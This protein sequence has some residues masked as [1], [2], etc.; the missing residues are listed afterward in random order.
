MSEEETVKSYKDRNVWMRG[1]YMVIFM[2]FWGVAEFV[3]FF[4]VLVQFLTVLFTAKTNDKLVRFGK[5]LCLYQYEILL[6][7][8]YNSEEHP[9][10]MGDW[11]EVPENIEKDEHEVPEYKSDISE[12]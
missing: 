4:V 5:S 7:L 3:A 1:L 11:P 9:Y 2:V 10:P 12:K 6:F 8:T